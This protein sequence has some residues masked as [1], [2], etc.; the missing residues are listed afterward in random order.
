M[1]AITKN[2]EQTNLAALNDLEA[3]KYKIYIAV[4]EN[5]P[6]CK[7]MEELENHLLKLGIQKQYK[8]K[9]QTNEKQG[10]SFKIGKNCFKGSQVDRKF[11]FIGLQKILEL[12]NKQTA[13][14][15]NLKQE[16]NRQWDSSGEKTFFSNPS[17]A[18]FSGGNGKESGYDL[19][20]KLEKAVEI[21]FKPEHTNDIISHELLKKKERRRRKKQSL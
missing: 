16:S 21:L 19:L 9:G 14:Q 2:L 5:L 8:Y 17:R 18:D 4:A 7:T 11:S 3:A 6:H 10:I 15:Q 1:P 13:E 12:Q 20:K